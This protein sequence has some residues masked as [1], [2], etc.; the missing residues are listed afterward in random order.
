MVALDQLCDDI[1]MEEMASAG[2]LGVAVGVESVD[3]DNCLAVGKRH[4]IGRPFP[5]AVNRANDLGSQSPTGID[6]CG[7]IWGDTNNLNRILRASFG[8]GSG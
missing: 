6:G 7:A 5:E 3:E 1:L 8:C 4:N 2:C